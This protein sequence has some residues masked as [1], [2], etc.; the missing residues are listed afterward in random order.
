MKTKTLDAR[1]FPFEKFQ[2]M[3]EIF[4]LAFVS[5]SPCISSLGILLKILS[6]IKLHCLNLYGSPYMI[7]LDSSCTLL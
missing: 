5:S 2:N 7:S 6:D 4:S 3:L 1:E